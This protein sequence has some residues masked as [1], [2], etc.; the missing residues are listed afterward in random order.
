MEKEALDDLFFFMLRIYRLICK[1]RLFGEPQLLRANSAQ[2]SFKENRTFLSQAVQVLV[3]LNW[4]HR[5][6]EDL[7]CVE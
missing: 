3:L 4:C 5:Y 7:V 1:T 6:E 2:S